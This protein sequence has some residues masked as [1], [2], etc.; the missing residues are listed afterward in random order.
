MTISSVT[1]WKGGE[2][3]TVVAVARRAKAILTRHG[4]I[5]H[6]LSIVHAGPDV[7]QWVLMTTYKD[8]E[9]FGKAMQKLAQDAEFHALLAEMTA[10]SQPTAHQ[11]IAN[12]HL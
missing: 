11:I 8:W 12:I 9:S 10:I 5:A 2:D 4:A 1:Y 6:D 7:G 3:E